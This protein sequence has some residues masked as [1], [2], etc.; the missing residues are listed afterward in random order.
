MIHRRTDRLGLV[1]HFEKAFNIDICHI[2]QSVRAPLLS[3]LF[4]LVAS[5]HKMGNMGISAYRDN[6]TNGIHDR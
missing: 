3:C 2:L 4:L 5:I 1:R 6:V